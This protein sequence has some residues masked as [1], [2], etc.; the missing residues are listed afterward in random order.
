MIKSSSLNPTQT[1]WENRI[2]EAISFGDFIEWRESAEYIRR[3]SELQAELVEFSKLY[4]LESLSYFEIFIAACLVKTNEMGARED[5]PFVLDDL[6]LNWGHCAVV[7]GI[8]G[9]DFIRRLDHW[10]NVD[11]YGYFS[12]LEIKIIPVLNQALRCAFEKSLKDRLANRDYN[13]DKIIRSFYFLTK[14]A[15]GLI[16]HC[17]QFGLTQE[18]CANLAN[19][20]LE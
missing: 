17:E 14:N 2:A 19:I 11:D 4:P 10:I 7:T 3:L 12:D 13:A 9:D 5:F 15:E 1:S 8:A 16:L 6:I 18:D 20:Y